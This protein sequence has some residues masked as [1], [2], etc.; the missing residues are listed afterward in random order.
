MLHFVLALLLIIGDAAISPVFSGDTSYRDPRRP[1]FTMLIPDSWT[2]TKTDQGVTIRRSP[3]YA[4]LHVAGNA[5]QPGAM[6]VQ[7]RPQLERQWKNF[8]EID[9]GAAMFGGQQGAYAIYA[10]VPPSGVR[11]IMKV[12]TMTNGRLTYTL[13]MGI[14]ADEYRQIKRDMDRIEASFAPDPVR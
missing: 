6:L 9:S 2:A 10:G 3:S 12:V 4:F 11:E 14:P 1:S 8:Q 5:V 13:Y 7:I